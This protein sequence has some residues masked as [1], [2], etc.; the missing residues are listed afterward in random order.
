MTTIIGYALFILFPLAMAYAA[1]SDVLTMTIPNR[2]SLALVLV[3]FLLAPVVGI[4]LE[5]LARHVAAAAIVLAVCFALFAFGW[6]GG[7]DAKL[8][9]AIALWLGLDHTLPF[10]MQ[11]AI[12]GGLLTLA[13]LAFRQYTLPVFAVGRQWIERL[14]DRKVGVPYGVALAAAAVAVYPQTPWFGFAA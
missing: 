11:T 4:G 6:F 2:L 3:F 1:I 8:A 13:L 14:H 7:G 9:A 5:D 12:W 10:V